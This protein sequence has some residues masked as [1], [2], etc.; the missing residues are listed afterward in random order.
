MSQLILPPRYTPDSIAL[1][2]A[3]TRANWKVHRL[4]SWSV[5]PELRNT[6]AVVYAEPLF[7]SAVAEP[8][9]LEVLEPSATWLP[10]L[11]RHYRNR[12]ISLVTLGQARLLEK[13]A[14]IK[15]I[16]DKCF[17]A[18]VYQSGAELPPP[19]TDL[20]DEEPTYLSEPVVWGIEFR[21]FVLDRQVV[22]IS[23]YLRD[24]ELVEQPDGS[25]AASEDE[26]RS[27]EDFCRV[28]LA[29]PQVPCPAAVVLDVGIIR[30]RGW[31]VI[32]ANAAWGSG[33]Y[34]CDPDGVLQTIRRACIP[35]GKVQPVDL[36]WLRK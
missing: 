12:E 2:K 30:G 16:S 21:A 24:G 14:F 32:E 26:I 25:W 36:P 23:P 1:G 10:E 5:P 11:P 7:I 18:K 9:G 4:H 20:G 17:M 28:V 22:T 31:S 8:L 33:L 3:A 27:A 15:P 19:P 6:D 35:K 29:D 13:P 34:G